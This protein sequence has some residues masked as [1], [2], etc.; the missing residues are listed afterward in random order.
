MKNLHSLIYY[1]M[2]QKTTPTNWFPNVKMISVCFLIVLLLVS[3][4]GYAQTVKQYAVADIALLKT[5]LIA[6]TYDIYELTDAGGLYVIPSTSSQ[7][8]TILK[9]FEIRAASGLATKPVVSISSTGSG[10]NATIFFP[11]APNLVIKM[12]GIEFDGVNTG[13]TIQNVCLRA[14]PLSTN[15]KV[16]IKDCYFHHFLNAAGNGTIRLDASSGSSIDIQG[17]TFNNCGGRILYFYSADASAA[18]ANGDLVLRNN[19]F[20]NI[21]ATTTYPNC[22]VHYKS[23]TSVPSIGANAFID[24]NTFYNIAISADEIFKIR[25]MTGVVN[26]TNCIFDQVQMGITFTSPIPTIDY[27]YLAGL[28]TQ[29]T[30]TNTIVTAPL[31]TDAATLNFGL[32]NRPQFVGS[33]ALTVGNT[34]YYGVP[35]AI[36][37]PVR[38]TGK[39]SGRFLVYPNPVAENVNFDYD[40]PNDAR[41]KLVIYNL[42]NQIVKAFVNNE[43]QGAGNHNN[44]FNV[45]GLKPGLYFAR[46]TMGNVSKTQKLVIKR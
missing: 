2:K 17:T 45:S 19:T 36:S 18:T 33:D 34:M 14:S 13:G 11:N 30:G 32:T 43:V 40:L 12:Q 28:A 24:H 4:N 9:S 25:S 39:E 20:C 29:P 8:L 26:I 38:L 21:T 16:I 15:C 7:S 35:T 1:D 5:D 27:C 46:L 44:S 10:T 6:G 23:T 42:N 41:V 22:V 3:Y 31:Y 37:A